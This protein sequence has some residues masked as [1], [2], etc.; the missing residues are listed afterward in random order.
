M[1]IALIGL[2]VFALMGGG[3][4]I[5]ANRIVCAVV[6]ALLHYFML[7]YFF[8]TAVESIDVYRKLV[9]VLGSKINHYPIYGGLVAW[10]ECLPSFMSSCLNFLSQE[11]PPLL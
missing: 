3:P 6:G 8:W 7:V 1:C 10:G 5:L 2:Y 9:I 4:I 11:F